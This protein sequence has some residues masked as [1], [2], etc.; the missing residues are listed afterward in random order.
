M[1]HHYHATH[2]QPGHGHDEDVPEEFKFTQEFWDDRYGSAGRL[3]SGQPNAQLVE[4]ASGL[5]PGE[6]L[7]AGCGEGGDAIWLAGQGWPVTAVDVSQ[8]ALDRGAAAAAAA[9]DGVAGRIRWRREDLLTWAPE[10]GR[11]GLVS[12]QYMHLPLEMFGDFLARLAAAVRPGGT[13]LVVGHHPDDLHANVGRHG[14]AHRFVLA[15]TLAADL[16]Q[17]SWEIVVA[18][19][20]DRPARDLD[21][22]AVTV[23][24]TVLRA[25]RRG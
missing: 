2:D 19:A 8:V 15:E 24:D 7:D 18:A 5:E 4:Q 6:A 21:G 17:E 13:L 12:A 1:P 9:G 14:P 3:W 23:R 10:P 22:Q 25:T 16:D 11:Y 20:F